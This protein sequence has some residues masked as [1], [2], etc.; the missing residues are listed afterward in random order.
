MQKQFLSRI[1]SLWKRGRSS[2]REDV[3]RGDAR[4]FLLYDF[5]EILVFPP[6]D[7]FMICVVLFVQTRFFPESVQ[8]SPQGVWE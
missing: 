4:L 8:K 5:P 7:V 2:E 1:G 6:L 3:S